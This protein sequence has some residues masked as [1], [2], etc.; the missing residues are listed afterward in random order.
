MQENFPTLSSTTWVLVSSSHPLPPPDPTLLI[1]C[2]TAA[3]AFL[4]PTMKAITSLLL[5]LT[6]N[7]EQHILCLSFCIAVFQGCSSH[8]LH[9][10][11]PP[12]S[13]ATAVLLPRALWQFATLI[14][15]PQP[16]INPWLYN[17]YGCWCGLGGGGTPLDEVDM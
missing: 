16:G 7:P 6:G 8:F 14:S 9:L 12:A 11:A 5:L 1:A 3:E 10:S 15:C 13:T 17:D 2:Q 4:T